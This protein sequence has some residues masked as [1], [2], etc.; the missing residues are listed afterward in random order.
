MSN[1]NEFVGVA[2]EEKL[3]NDLNNYASEHDIG[4]IAIQ[5]ELSMVQKLGSDEDLIMVASNKGAYEAI[6]WVLHAGEK[7]LPVYDVVAS[8]TSRFASQSGILHRLRLMREHGLLMAK[9]GPKKS[10]VMLCASDRLKSKIIPL[11]IERCRS[12]GDHP[13][14]NKHGKT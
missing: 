3:M 14:A 13:E 8:V 1:F 4:L 10:Q 12:V 6:L 11:M 5:S 9:P 7:G 2:T